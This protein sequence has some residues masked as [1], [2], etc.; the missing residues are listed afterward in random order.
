[1]A[2]NIDGLIANLERRGLQAAIPAVKE[3]LRVGVTTEHARV[4]ALMAWSATGHPNLRAVVAEAIARGKTEAE[5]MPQLIAA[6]SIVWADNPPDVQ[7][8]AS[9]PAGTT[10]GDDELVAAATALARNI[11]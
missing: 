10:D 11:H 5:V 6:A 8:R 9:S 2:S 1:M 4:T 3:A 7:T